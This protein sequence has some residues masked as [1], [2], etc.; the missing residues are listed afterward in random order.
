MTDIQTEIMPVQS[1][2]QYLGERSTAGAD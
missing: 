1:Q 2:W